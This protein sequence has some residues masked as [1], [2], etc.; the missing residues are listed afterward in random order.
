MHRFQF[1]AMTI[2]S[3]GYDPQRALLEIKFTQDEQI[4]QY[5]GVPEELWYGLKREEQPDTYFRKYIRGCYTE[6]QMKSA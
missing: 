5:I 4:W 3:A 2:E 6:R 1:G